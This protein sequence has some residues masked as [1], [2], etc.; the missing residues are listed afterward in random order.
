VSGDPVG[1]DELL[2]MGVR[3]RDEGQ[4]HNH[5]EKCNVS[6]RVLGAECWVLRCRGA[7]VLS[8]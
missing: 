8:E 2:R 4:H 7:A 1:V 6:S 5:G 3:H